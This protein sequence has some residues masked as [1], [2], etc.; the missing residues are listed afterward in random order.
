[1]ADPGFLRGREWMIKSKVQGRGKKRVKQLKRAW[2]S[3]LRADT[4]LVWMERE[5]RIWEVWAPGYMP[6]YAE[7]IEAWKWVI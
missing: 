6:G 4:R 2:W 1:M 5:G 7:R 3:V